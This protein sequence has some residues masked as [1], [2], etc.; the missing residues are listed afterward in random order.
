MSI[1]EVSDTKTTEEFLTLPFKI[2]KNDPHWVPH[3]RQDIEKVFN[4]DKNKFFR[5]GE[6]IRWILVKDGETIGRVAAFVNKKA[7]QKQALNTGGI[8]F[9]ECIKDQDAAFE[10][11]DAGKKWLKER[12]LDAMDGPIN[13]GEKD[14]FWGLITENFEYP[15]YYNQNYNPDYYVPFFENYGFKVYYEQFIYYRKTTDELIP[16]LKEKSARIKKD[17]KFTFDTIK[18]NNLEKYAEDFRTIYNRA[19][20]KHE[21]FAGME[22]RQAMTIM[23]TIKPILDED[24]IHFAYYDGTP[25]GFFIAL[26]E[27]N[28]IFKHVN[29]NLNWW[30]K[31]KFLY[32]KL[33][34]TCTTFFGLAF[35]I[36]PDFQSKGLEGAIFDE[37]REVLMKKG[38]YEDVVITW[39]GDFNPKMI[40]VIEN[41]GAKKLRTLATYRY[42]FDREAKFERAKVIQ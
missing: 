6:A 22:K 3:L 31:L 14:K 25:V 39:I 11:F 41:L 26:P 9:F 10:L 13:F 19:W 4:P 33:K 42:L 24:L 35:G 40:H 27:I 8:G 38:K 2:Y 18:K 23:K 29:G 16:L 1:I 36:D 30:G 37:C 5:H 21:G 17:N 20:V 7:N 34:G 12:E 28:Q 32:H 15:P